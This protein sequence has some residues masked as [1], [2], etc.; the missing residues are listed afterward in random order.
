MARSVRGLALASHPAPTAMVTVLALA[1]LLGLRAPAG[2][3]A[4]AVAAVLTGQLSVGWSNDWFDAAR[5][6][7]VGRT[8]KPLVTGMLTRQQLGTAAIVA[9]GACAV[10]SWSTGAVPGTVH[11]IAV[12]SAWAYNARLK[13]SVW[14]WAP[15]ALS[16]AL[17]PTF[18]ALAVPGRAVPTWLWV[19]GALLGAG[20]HVANVLPDLDDDAATGVRGL[21][22]RLGRLGSSVLAPA[23]LGCA[24]VVVTVA[25]AGPP[26]PARLIGLFGC[27]ALAAAAGVVGVTRRRS[28]MPFTLSLLV[29]AVCVLLLVLA[30]ADLWA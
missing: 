14:S 18:L 6:R 16:F 27:L 22:H 8:D 9:A 15:Y 25:P 4:L 30:G 11:V 20:A 19:A 2:T 28:R 12:A 1:L 5:D 21:P 24:A 17:L 10:L 23:L 13:A 26:D 29:A 7:R 3:V